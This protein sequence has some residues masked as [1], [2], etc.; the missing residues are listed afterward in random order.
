MV[1]GQAPQ[2]QPDHELHGPRKNK[3]KQHGE[4]EVRHR[5]AELG[6]GH[7]RVVGGAVGRQPD[8]DREVAVEG[9][10]MGGDLQGVEDH[11]GDHGV[12]R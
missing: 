6:G 9:R 7:H 12:G 2:N 11:A 1:A 10:A 4:P 8:A 3:D 5:D